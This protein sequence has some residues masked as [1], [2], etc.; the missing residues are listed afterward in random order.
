MTTVA[1]L[2]AMS[3]VAAS[4]DPLPTPCPQPSRPK[5]YFSWDFI[6]LAFHG[7]NRYSSVAVTLHTTPYSVTWMLWHTPSRA[8]EPSHV[9]GLESMLRFMIHARLSLRTAAILPECVLPFRSK[10]DPSPSRHIPA[11]LPGCVQQ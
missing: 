1:A 3:A 9:I 4:M 11:I 10:R 2:V 5:P 7:A 6:P 8:V